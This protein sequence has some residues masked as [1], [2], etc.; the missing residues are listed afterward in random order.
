MAFAPL[1]LR[2]E[3]GLAFGSASKSVALFGLGGLLSNVVWGRFYE[4]AG[5]RQRRVATAASTAALTAMCAALA[6]HAFGA[7]ALSLQG[8][9]AA[10]FGI[11]F[12]FAGPYYVPSQ[13]IVVT[14]AGDR[15]ATVSGVIDA[16]G[17]VAVCVLNYQ[18]QTLRWRTA[19]GFLTGMS[20]VAG[21]SLLKA[22]SYDE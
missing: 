22:M 13:V 12:T 16:L 20:A 11:G 4:A 2:T 1:Y 6:A 15:T 8:T 14:R 19:W 5:R 9:L 10:I 18:C 7:V 17:F 3:Y 21:V